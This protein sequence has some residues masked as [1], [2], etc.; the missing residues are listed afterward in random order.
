MNIHQQFCINSCFINFAIFAYIL[1]M[2]AK[3][4]NNKS[5][6]TI[7]VIRL[8]VITGIYTFLRFCFYLVNYSYFS[9]IDAKELAVI[10]LHGIRFDLSAIAVINAFVI[11]ME[12][13]PFRFRFY[14]AYRV[15]VTVVFYLSN[16]IALV[17]NIIDFAYFR[18]SFKRSTAELLDFM[19]NEGEVKGSLTSYVRDFWYLFLLLILCI[20]I[21]IWVDRNIKALKPSIKSAENKWKGWALFIIAIGVLIIMYRG[22]LQQRKLEISD[23]PQYTKSGTVVLMLNTPFAIIR[24]IGTKNLKEINYFPVDECNKI[25]SALH[26]PLRMDSIASDKTRKNIVIIILEGFSSEY[27]SFMNKPHGGVNYK[28]YTPFL[29]SL[30]QECQIFRC[31]SNSKHSIEGIPSII[32]SIPPF[33]N[34][35]FVYSPYFKDTIN[36]LPSLLKSMGY[37]S[38]FFHGGNNGTMMLDDFAKAVGFNKYYGRKEYNNDKD[39]DGVWGIHDEPFLQFVARTVRKFPEPFLVSVFTVSSHHP[40]NI[41]KKY[42]KHFSGGPLP[43]HQTLEYAD[44]SIGRFFQTIRNEKWFRNSVFLIIS[45]HSSE[46]MSAYY[47]SRTGNYEIPLM[48]YEP[49]SKKQRV[50]TVIAQQTDVLPTILSM[51]GYNRSYISFGNNLLDTTAEHFSI[52]YLDN[53]FQLIKDGYVLQFDGVQTFAFYDFRKD[54]ILNN[55]LVSLN[56]AKKDELERFLKAVIQNYNNRLIHNGLTAD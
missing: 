38:A 45:D 52:S 12:C 24:S 48:I 3:K 47:K 33:M 51:V 19:A 22:G 6:V 43:I 37:Y 9:G 32:A 41:P 11:F 18:F 26:K 34:C 54:S 36:A 39:F 27:C 44:Y 30:S 35:P 10:F 16:I 56:M 1:V 14:K 17:F 46:T 55:N 23:A 53:T 49:G 5:I 15:F 31:F 20:A 2:N 25:F 7:L 13:I 8:L 50:S 40:Y 21:M 4:T 28:G 42:Q 29:D